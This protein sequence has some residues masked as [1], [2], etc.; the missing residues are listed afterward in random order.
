MI[1]LFNVN[2]LEKCIKIHYKIFKWSDRTKKTFYVKHFDTVPG[3]LFSSKLGA[4][5]EYFLC[6]WRICDISFEK[7]HIDFAFDAFD[8]YPQYTFLLHVLPKW[9]VSVWLG[10]LFRSNLNSISLYCPISVLQGIQSF[11]QV[12]NVAANCS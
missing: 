7:Y 5:L 12:L 10:D 8:F 4:K 2:I 1:V 3:A 9:L 11:K 6:L